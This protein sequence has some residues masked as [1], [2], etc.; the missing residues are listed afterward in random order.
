MTPIMSTS[1]IAITPEQR[2][3]LLSAGEIIAGIDTIVAKLEPLACL[4]GDVMQ[5]LGLLRVANLA[6]DVIKARVGEV[7]HV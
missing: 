6:R 7:A 2:T 4:R 5:A 3:L 1:I